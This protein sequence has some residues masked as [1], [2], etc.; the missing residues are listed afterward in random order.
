MPKLNFACCLFLFKHRITRVSQKYKL[1][2][3]HRFLYSL[4]REFCVI[5][6]LKEVYFD[7]LIRGNS[8]KNFFMNYAMP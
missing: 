5:P 1:H 4:F 7:T 2:G 3:K 8:K 6:C